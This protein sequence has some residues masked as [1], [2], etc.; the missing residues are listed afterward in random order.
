L[1]KIG[2]GSERLRSSNFMVVI[3]TSEHRLCAP[4]R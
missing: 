4:S 1:T 2:K 3:P